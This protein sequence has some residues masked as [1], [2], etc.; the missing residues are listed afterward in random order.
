ML[1]T[2]VKHL[3]KIQGVRFQMDEFGNI[4]AVKGQSES[5]V[6][7]SAHLDTVHRIRHNYKVHYSKGVF[8]ATSGNKKTGIGG[9]DKCGII[10]CLHLLEVSRV[11]VKV[12][13]FTD[14]E[15]GCVGS[16]GAR[17]EFF[18]DVGLM[19]GVDRRGTSDLITDYCGETISAECREFI[20]PVADKHGYIE[21]HGLITDVFTIQSRLKSPVSAINVSCGY[22]NPH[23]D[24][25]FI[26]VK[27][28]N[29][30]LCL[31]KDILYSYDGKTMYYHEKKDLF[32]Y[33]D[34]IYGYD[35][36]DSPG[37]SIEESDIID[38]IV[39]ELCYIVD[40]SQVSVEQLHVD[41]V[42]EYWLVDF[43]LFRKCYEKVVAKL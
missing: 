22:F 20:I 34:G 5:Y 23:T 12:A 3:Q 13:L 21:T 33:W 39:Q 25:D 8:Y 17:L 9:D 41:Y 10:L 6:C 27:G 29:G 30:C 19:V 14:E 11:P 1:D 43:E 7:F 36:D 35:F 4:F 18:K 28:L 38:W 15:I 42:N 32:S 37:F 24:K 31:L 26:S 2:I 40:I 16:H